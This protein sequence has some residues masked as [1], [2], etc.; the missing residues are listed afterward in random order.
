MTP[1]LSAP[2]PEHGGN[3]QHGSIQSVERYMAP[4]LKQVTESILTVLSL[5]IWIQLYNINYCPSNEM[6]NMCASIS[7]VCL[8]VCL[9]D[10]MT[11][12]FPI[13]IFSTI[14]PQHINCQ[15]HSVIYYIYQTLSIATI[16]IR[17]KIIYQLK[18][19][20][21]TTDDWVNDIPHIF[22]LPLQLFTKFDIIF[23]GQRK[24]V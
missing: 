19:V 8:F 15:N 20:D 24:H 16:F 13:F 1:S 21:K 5:I 22:E 12:A 10:S 2:E 11:Q 9:F 14:Q 23:Y 17:S 18:W 7:F 6:R 4:R 3:S